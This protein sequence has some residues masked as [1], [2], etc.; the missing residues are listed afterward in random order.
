[1]S[2]YAIVIYSP[3]R[4]GESESSGEVRK[5]HQQHADDLIG[6]GQMVAAFSL[7]G[8]DSAVVIQDGLITDGPFAESKEVIGGFYVVEAS[9]RDAAVRI[10]RGN[11]AAQGGGRIEVRPVGGAYLPGPR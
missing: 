10:A 11:P 4:S 2:Q 8:A 5:A 7:E 9:D 1:M 3:D 6:S